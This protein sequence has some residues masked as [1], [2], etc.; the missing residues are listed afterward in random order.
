MTVSDPE[1]RE[2]LRK[3]VEYEEQ[4]L[5]EYETNPIY[6]DL[7]EEAKQ[8]WWDWRDVGVDWRVVHRLNIAGFLKATGGRRKYYM[9]KDRERVKQMLQESVKPLRVEKVEVPEDL[10]DVVEGFDDLKLFLKM[11]LKKDAKVHVLL[12]GPPGVAKSAILKEIERLPGSYFTT[13]GTTRR[14]GLAETLI[15]LQPR[16]LIIDEI[17]KVVDPKDLSALLTLME[18]QRVVVTKHGMRTSVSFRC[19]VF[20][21][22]NRLKNL[23]PELIDRFEV[24]HIKPYT[25]E[26]ARRVIVAY[27][28]KRMGK[29]QRLAEYI[30][31]R[32]LT[33]STS[34]REAIRVAELC[35]SEEEVDTVVRIVKKYHRS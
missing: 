4:K 12:V 10:F 6:A 7:P 13:G 1:M 31:D 3:I 29:P 17:D 9:L 20:A 27:L 23:P 30:A 19:N 28:T 24:F 21:A 8:P 18:D 26:Q 14:A 22:A 35:D 16:F 5:K 11:V 25:P 33:Y 2:A 32:V 34:I 15:E